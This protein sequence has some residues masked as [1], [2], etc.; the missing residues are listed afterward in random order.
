MWRSFYTMPAKQ[1]CFLFITIAQFCFI[2]ICT[3]QTSEKKDASF[4]HIDQLVDLSYTYFLLENKDSAKLYA[5]YAYNEGKRLNYN[6]GIARALL[7]KAQI[8]KHFD[9]DFKQ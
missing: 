9:D 3:A 6:H 2:A 8:A 7:R 5:G 1:Y 4:N